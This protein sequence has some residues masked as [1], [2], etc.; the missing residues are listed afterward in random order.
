MN[1]TTIHIL[2]V[3][4]N[5]G[6]AELLKELLSEERNPAFS[7]TITQR[8]A[9]S[10]SYLRQEKFDAIL[11][12]LGLPD[13]SGMDTLMAVRSVSSIPIIILT[14]LADE[15]FAVQAIKAGADDYLV[16][17]QINRLLV[18]RTIRYAIERK[19]SEDEFKISEARFRNLFEQSPISVQ[20]F[21]PDGRTVEVNEAWKALWGISPDALNGYNI[22]K[23]EQLAKKGVI[24]YIRR[25][26]SGE[27]SEIPAVY[28][29]PAEIGIQGNA[30]WVR[31]FIYPVKDE[32][33][34]IRQVV[35]THLDITERMAAERE[36][37]ES[38]ERYRIVTESA[39]DAIFTIDQNSIIVLTNPAAERLFGYALSELK[40]KP[41]TML[42]P[43]RLRDAHR[44]AVKRFVETGKRG[45]PWG[46]IELPGLHRDGREIPLEISYGDFQQAGRYFFIGVVRD[47]SERK[48][49]EGALLRTQAL[50]RQAGRMANL[51]AWE[52][53][54]SANLDLEASHLTWSDQVYRIFGYEP[55]EVEV[56]SAFFFERVHRDDREK[57]GRALRQAIVLK[58]PFS[59]EHRIIRPD[60]EE[61]VVAGYAEATY[62]EQG[63]PVRMVGAVQDITERKK[64]EDLIRYQ[65]YHDLLT[66]LPNREQFMVKLGL[67]VAQAERNRSKLAVAHL[68]LDRFKVINDTLGHSVGD[69]LIVAV[70][71]RLRTLIR[72]SDTLA[73]AGSDEFIIL[74]ADLRNP[75]DAARA[76]VD[77]LN[78]MRHLFEI[79]NKMLYVTASIGISMFPE[80][81]RNPEVLLSNADIAVSH[82]K[83][84]GRD[85]YQFF[86]PSINVRTLERLLLESNLRQTIERNQ[87]VVYYQPQFDIR[88]GRIVCVEALVRWMHPDL[89]L[90]HPTQFL[91]VAEE[92]GFMPAIDEWVLRTACV[93]NKLW[94]ESGHDL[95][96]TVNV[97]AQQFQRADLV[98]SVART[99]S[100]AG[101][102]P[103]FLDIEVTEGTAM[104]DI[105]LAI[106]NLK[107][108]HNLGVNLS[109][110]DFGTG[111]SS[112]NYLKR[113]PVQ[114][115]K[116]DQSFIRGIATDTDDQAIVRAV[117]AMGHNLR[118]K[119]LAEG[120]ETNEQ[121]EFLREHE[122]DEMQGFLYSQPVPP[123][124]IEHAFLSS[125]IKPQQH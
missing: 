12:D 31:A 52:I 48:R 74:L 49:A 70:A 116:I 55:G 77:I 89:G 44:T 7:I 123:D 102:S 21:S 35:L 2:L 114:T 65:T 50:L 73:R 71:D 112:L 8:L 24:S 59:V 119:I 78:G 118:L 58:Q 10:E 46:S 99:I 84:T 14:G 97:S 64:A 108:L 75:E 27:S 122:C 16:K 32:D 17:A 100:H 1:D 34:K 43:E 28:Y 95:C 94:H 80:D 62:E 51:G 45:L 121:L 19:R 54:L 110:D 113:F 3:E 81:S 40:G 107:G 82:T 4:D 11:L 76:V 111:Y 30:R 9:D 6:D 57:L 37:R 85:N 68:D 29:D 117:I 18:A 109:I 86:N 22:L 104:R 115:L 60:G 106:P 96:V 53:E 13:S 61:R 93:Q 101:L 124:E 25:G 91:P 90:L 72:Q 92:I 103:R 15:E 56:T 125:V 20:I 63:L 120:V 39:H 47:I 66:G 88:S 33:G 69:R 42:M 79:D 87:L 36:F 67:E 23:D 38:E 105:D 26:F 98:D 5:P 41:L 83:E